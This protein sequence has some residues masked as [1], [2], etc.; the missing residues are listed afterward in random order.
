MG[1]L[2]CANT[3]WTLPYLWFM[4]YH[5]V[6]GIGITRAMGQCEIVPC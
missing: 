5:V 3:E 6:G 4:V 1:I 2:V